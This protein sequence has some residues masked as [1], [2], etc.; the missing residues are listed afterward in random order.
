[1]NWKTKEE[2]WC[3]S[4]ESIHDAECASEWNTT[5]PLQPEYGRL[6]CVILDEGKMKKSPVIICKTRPVSYSSNCPPVNWPKG[7]TTHT[8]SSALS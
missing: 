1:M 7:R 3:S 6:K 5:E 4:D 8:V 2:K